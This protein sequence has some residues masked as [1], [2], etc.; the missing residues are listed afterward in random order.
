MPSR[1]D[2]CSRRHRGGGLDR[3]RRRGRRFGPR[4]ARSGEP[5]G[6]RDPAARAPI[7]CERGQMGR[8]VLGGPMRRDLVE[9]AMA[10]DHDAFSE[11][12]RA[13]I[14][15]L[16]AAA[17]PD[18]SRRGDG[19]R[20]RPRRRS[21]PPGA[22]S[23]RCATPIASMPGSIGCW[24]AACYREARRGRRRWA[25]R[26]GGPAVDRRSSRD[27]APRPRRPRRARTWL[28]PPRCRPAVGD[29][30]ALLPR[31]DPRRG[32]RRARHP[33]GDRPL[34]PPPGH[35]AM[36]AALDADAR[37][38]HHTNERRLA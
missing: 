29:R 26:D 38:P 11:L 9:R 30:P 34:A 33:A 12:A 37:L 14:G 5:F 2:P 19:P 36:R 16:Y 17:L 27:P 28:P 24:S 21:S 20:T 31:P 32:R 23:P 15:R 10:G 3:I 6:N 1:R 35:P 13:S 7:S 18:P 22:T 4:D 25:D 8:A